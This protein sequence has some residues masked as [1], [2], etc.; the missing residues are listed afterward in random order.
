MVSSRLARAAKQFRSR[1]LDATMTDSERKLLDAGPGAIVIN[2][3][4]ALEDGSTSLVCNPRES[5]DEDNLSAVE[6]QSSSPRAEQI[7]RRINLR[8]KHDLRHADCGARR[9][10]ETCRCLTDA[11]DQLV[12]AEGVT[13]DEIVSL[14]RTLHRQKRAED[15]RVEQRQKKALELARARRAQEPTR[16]RAVLEQPASPGASSESVTEAKKP[17]P[18]PR[19]L[20][21]ADPLSWAAFRD[22][23]DGR[24]DWMRKQF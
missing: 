1:E 4:W 14:A 13:R 6:K 24:I 21:P 7:R 16:A 18:R 23:R 15:K 2:L 11:L 5:V 20:E 19:V 17:K 8:V 10:R 9:R 3:G 22:E 12:D